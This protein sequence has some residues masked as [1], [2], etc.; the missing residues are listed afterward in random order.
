MAQLVGSSDQGWAVWGGT[1]SGTGTV[2]TAGSG[3][4]AYGDSQGSYGVVG[5]SYASNGTG[6]RGTGYVGVRG[7]GGAAGVYGIGSTGLQAIGTGSV[8]T[9]VYAAGS[10]R[11]A[12]LNGPVLVSG[13]LSKPGGGFRLDHPRNPANK[14][15]NH[16]FVESS[17]M[18]NVY[19]GVAQLDEDGAAW[20]DLPEWFE[21]LN[22]DFRYQLTAVGGA[23]PNLHVAE[24]IYE[25]RFRI[26][27]GEGG[28]KVCWQVTGTRKDPWAAANPFEVEEDKPQEEQGHYLHPDLYGKPED[29]MLARPEQPPGNSAQ[30]PGS[31]ELPPGMPPPGFA[32][33][34]FGHLG[35][36]NLDE[37][38]GQIQELRRQIE[39]LKRRG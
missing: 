28:M 5:R 22:G 18:K 3:V 13:F 6:V 37:L 10:Y 30:P 39:E 12:W 20:V 11:A 35:A 4:G 23:A 34:G 9:G 19:D 7:E 1:N 21:I 24:E 29:Q 36:E 15:L 32:A 17:E 2:G 8:G 26:A 27:G 31:R 14:Y 33:P 38:R 16:S 25:N